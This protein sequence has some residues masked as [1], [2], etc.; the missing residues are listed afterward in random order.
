MLKMV[1]IHTYYANSYVLQGISLEIAKATA[2]AF[3]G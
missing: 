3:L 1:D 2:P